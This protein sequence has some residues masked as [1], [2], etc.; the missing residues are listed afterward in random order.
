MR[1]EIYQVCP[2]GFQK[3]ESL[4][5]LRFNDITDVQRAALGAPEITVRLLQQRIM[6]F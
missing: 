2:L 4:S 6:H 5:K 3:L 1:E